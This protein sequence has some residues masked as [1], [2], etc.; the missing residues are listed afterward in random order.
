MSYSRADRVA[1]LIKEELSKIIRNEIKDPRIKGIYSI[2]KVELSK[3]YRHANVYVSVMGNEEEQD[4]FFEGLE[5][6]KGYIKKL[7]GG[8]IRL[9]YTPDL[10]FK[11]DESIEHGVKI[12]TILK[13]IKEGDESQA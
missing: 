4:E 10:I 6:A 12:S 13:R 11:Q 2:T 1:K 9:R 7:I 5:K 3:D 8:R